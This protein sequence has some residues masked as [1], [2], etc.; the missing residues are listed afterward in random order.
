MTV[1]L[2][3][4]RRHMLELKLYRARDR[5]QLDIYLKGT[6]WPRSGESSG[7][8]ARINLCLHA[9]RIT[10]SILYV[11][12]CKN[13][14]CRYVRQFMVFRMDMYQHQAIDLFRATFETLSPR[15][16]LSFDSNALELS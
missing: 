6:T 13:R 9:G 11:T 2:C 12:F 16:Q 5:G 14:P 10:A 1:C 7:D 4:C 15:W 3:F 8:E